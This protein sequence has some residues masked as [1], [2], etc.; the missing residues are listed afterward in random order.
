MLT[1]PSVLSSIKEIIDQ[2]Q[3]MITDTNKARPGRPAR[4]S[5]DAILAAGLKL[6]EAKGYQQ[7]TRDD[8]AAAV[9]ASPAAISF[10]FGTM[11]QFQ[12]AV[13]RAAVHQQNLRVIA[14]GLA[15]RDPQALHASPELQQKAV[16]A[17]KG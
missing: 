17:I 8:L 4:I 7:V 3:H 16:N 11:H 9:E 1:A 15:V 14:Q 2:H 13:M 10:H 5:G 12:R 6:A